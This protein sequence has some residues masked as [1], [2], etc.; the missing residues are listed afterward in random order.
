MKKI[1]VTGA[2][3][4]I[5][6]HI[7]LQLL[8]A[9]Y[10]VRGSVRSSMREAELRDAMASH[11][12]EETLANLEIVQLD[13]TKDT[14][15]D[16]ALMGVDGLFHTASPFVIEEPRDENDLIRPAVD[17]TLR[18]LKAAKAAEVRRVVLTSSVVSIIGTQPRAGQTRLDEQDW[19][20]VN[21]PLTNIYGKSKTLAERAAWEFAKS[22]NLDLTVINPGMVLGAPVDNIHGASLSVIERLMAGKDPMVPRSGLVVVHVKDV[23]KAHIK[24]FEIDASIGER[25]I[26]ANEWFWFR[27]LTKALKQAFPDR[28]I[29]TRQAPDLLIRFLA[30]FD[31]PLRTV[32]PQLGREYAVSN[33]KAKSILGM[34]FI[35]GQTAIIESGRY[36]AN[37]SG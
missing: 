31:K 26:A 12:N 2:S 36:I 18:A 37:Q 24:A 32:V 19:S 33:T 10:S 25:I 22:N 27:D 9:G 1:L 5:A 4:Y 20:D 29:P 8:Q 6:K 21:S 16:A 11:L 28:K 30:L 7:V 17:G 13:L 3:G 34:D 15:W 35:T 23:A 14:G